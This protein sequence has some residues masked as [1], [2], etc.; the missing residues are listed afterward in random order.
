LK[1]IFSYVHQ[2]NLKHSWALLEN[3]SVLSVRHNNHLTRQADVPDELKSVVATGE[4]NTVE[5]QLWTTA[6][7]QLRGIKLW[8]YFK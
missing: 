6:Q 8:D 7:D 3:P 5:L 1:N 4:D 2:H